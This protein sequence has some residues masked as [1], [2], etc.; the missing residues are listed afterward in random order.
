MPS[1]DCPDLQPQSLCWIVGE[2]VETALRNISPGALGEKDA[3]PSGAA[4]LL[5][6]FEPVS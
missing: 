2:E 4:A 5:C 6:D 3:I 1:K